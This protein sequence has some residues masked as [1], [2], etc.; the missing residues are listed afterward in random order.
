M[1][2]YAS[3]PLKATCHCGVVTLEVP[4]RPREINEC[5]CTICRR[6]GAAWAYYPPKEVKITV[7]DGSPTKAYV[8]GDKES[9]FHFCSVCGCDMYW[10]AIEDRPE[11]GVNTRMMDPDELHTVTRKID[12]EVLTTCLKAGAEAHPQDKAQY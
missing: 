9:E 3:A 11:M 10:K 12:Y 4:H 1:P 7:K 2:S 8:W 5:Q 6:Y